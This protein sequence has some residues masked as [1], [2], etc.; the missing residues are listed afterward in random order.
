MCSPLAHRA[1][2]LEP[3]LMTSQPPS[4]SRLRRLRSAAVKRNLFHTARCS[5]I[6]LVTGQLQLLDARVSEMRALIANAVVYVPAF[7]WHP[8][9]VSSSAPPC[10]FADFLRHVALARRADFRQ[11]REV[12]DGSGN[13]HVKLAQEMGVYGDAAN[14]SLDGGGLASVVAGGDPVLPE[15]LAT[16]T[17]LIGGCFASV[18]AGGG[19]VLSKPLA[20][21][22]SLD[23]SVLATSSSLDGVGCASFVTVQ[24]LLLV[25]AQC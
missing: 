11:A 22:S 19:P 17:S 2:R 4:A 12:E 5:D 14:S 20:T 15:P 13:L 18:S 24:V 8:Q 21:S 3:S 25:G 7:A 23:G 6:S 1:L 16:S 9:D 10:V